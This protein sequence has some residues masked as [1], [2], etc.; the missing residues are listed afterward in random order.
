MP[1]GTRLRCAEI[2]ALIPELAAEEGMQRTARLCNDLVSEGILEK[3]IENKVVYFRMINKSNDVSKNEIVK[4]ETSENNITRD[5]ADYEAE[6]I[7]IMERIIK[8]LE[9]NRWY[10]CAEIKA[11]VPQLSE[12]EGTQHTA[13]LC[14]DLSEK[15]S[16]EK[17]IDKK[18]V[19][20]KVI[21]E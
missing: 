2:K 19:Y 17:M 4:S 18:V 20:F 5:N 10:R 16:L 12:E 21:K 11:L 9:P 14:N 8:T 15:G 6:N 13:R 7:V 1:Y 3:I